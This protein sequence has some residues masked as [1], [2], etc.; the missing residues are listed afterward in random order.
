MAKGTSC[1]IISPAPGGPAAGA[2]AK[3]GVNKSLLL[4]VR[5]GLRP[6]ILGS[7]AAREYNQG[8]RESNRAGAIREMKASA[9]SALGNG[10]A[11][12]LLS[13]NF[14]VGNLERASQKAPVA[15]WAYRSPDR[16]ASNR[17][18]TRLS[19]SS[20]QFSSRLALA[21]SLCSSHSE[22]ASRICAVSWLLSSRS[23]ANISRGVT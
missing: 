20:I 5:C 4:I 21:T 3:A 12:W 6:P 13:E 7:C 10:A 2:W 16:L 9:V 22:C 18:Q 1:V 8:R 23:S 15:Q 17:N 11:T 19:A 14:T